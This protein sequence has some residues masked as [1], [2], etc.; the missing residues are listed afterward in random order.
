MSKKDEELKIPSLGE[1]AIMAE[2]MEEATL[3]DVVTPEEPVKIPMKSIGKYVTVKIPNVKQIQA[4][5]AASKGKGKEEHSN[6]LLIKKTLVSPQLTMKQIDNLYPGFVVEY[7][8]IIND[9][10]GL[11]DE[12]Q[13]AMENLPEEKD[14]DSG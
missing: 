12:A 9:L 5:V 1:L 2:S 14:S 3:D 4:V 10:A 8:K 11:S 13:K 6:L 7:V